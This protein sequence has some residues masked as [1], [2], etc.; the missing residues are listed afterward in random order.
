MRVAH[1]GLESI[2][3]GGESMRDCGARIETGA[4]EPG[5]LA[6]D[7]R[8]VVVRHRDLEAPERALF[9]DL[10]R[11]IGQVDE[12][13]VAPSLDRIGPYRIAADQGPTACEIEFPV[14]PVA[15]E[16]AARSERALAQG[17]AFVR[18]AIGDREKL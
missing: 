4:F 15:G 1:T 17:V 12:N 2:V 18:A 13:L 6:R 8:V 5:N 9:L 7:P 16:H 11:R 14:V 10:R 3:A